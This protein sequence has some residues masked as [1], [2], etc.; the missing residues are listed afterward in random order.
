MKIVDMDLVGDYARRIRPLVQLAQRAYGSR[1]T[2]SLQHD[3]SRE[4]TR[5]LVEFYS[6]GGSLLK[7]AEELGVTYAG[8]RRRVMTAELPA[9]AARRTR[10]K[11]SDTEYAQAVGKLLAVQKYGSSGQY[12]EEIKDLYDAGYSLSRIA[13]LM[14][15]SSA[16]PLYYGVSRVAVKEEQAKSASDA[17]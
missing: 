12:H 14:G 5:L 17:A 9:E 2:R 3:A 16:N 13:K 8:L 11:Y 1:S 15:M 7:L 10:K 6:K 4:Y